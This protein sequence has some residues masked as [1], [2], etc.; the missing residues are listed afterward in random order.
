V[1]RGGSV[2]VAFAHHQLRQCTVLNSGHFPIVCLFDTD[3]WYGYTGIGVG[4]Y[5]IC[6]NCNSSDLKRVS[7]IHASGVYK[8]RGRF[9]GFLLGN[10]DAVHFGK[11][12]GTSQ[13]RLSAMVSPPRKGRYVAPTVLWLLGFFMLIAFDGRGK[14]STLMAF[15]SV[16]YVF[17]L[18]AYLLAALSYNLFIRR[19]KY[20]KWE[21]QFLCQ[22]CGAIIEPQTGRLNP[23]SSVISTQNWSVPLPSRKGQRGRVLADLPCGLCQ[24]YYFFFGLISSGL[25]IPSK[26]TRIC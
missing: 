9:R 13:S 16:A 22:L 18:P 12:R 21:S 7:L 5:M 26:T 3:V 1:C 2:C 10:S 24:P 4:H 14:L 11:Y 6:P 17:L 23:S 20:R 25:N 8:S 15:I 19:K